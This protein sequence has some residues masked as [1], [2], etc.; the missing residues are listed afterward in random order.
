MLRLSEDAFLI[1]ENIERL[2]SDSYIFKNYIISKENEIKL[3]YIITQSILFSDEIKKQ[4]A[5]CIKGLMTILDLFKIHNIFAD[6]LNLNKDIK[7]PDYKTATIVENMFKYIIDSIDT[8]G[9]SVSDTVDSS[10]EKTLKCTIASI[11]YNK[12]KMLF[13]ILLLIIGVENY[14]K[15]GY[16]FKTGGGNENC[17]NFAN[18]LYKLMHEFFFDSIPSKDP[19]SKCRAGRPSNRRKVG[20]TSNKCKINRSSNKYKADDDSEEYIAPNKKNCNRDN[21]TTAR[22]TRSGGNFIGNII[23]NF[24]GNITEI[25][26][27]DSEMFND[28]LLQNGRDLSFSPDLFGL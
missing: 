23:D 19:N 28:Q 14:E 27:Y 24:I 17:N 11:F 8:V 3:E 9:S 2:K 26:K 25:S 1:P 15:I 5:A 21:T 10:A 22:Q 12:R 4:T 20:R 16:T 7:W 18:K 6:G 13:F